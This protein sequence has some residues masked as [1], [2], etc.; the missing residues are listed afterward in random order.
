MKPTDLSTDRWNRVSDVLLQALE[1]SSGER[2]AVLDQLC[3]GDEGL[4]DE[5]LTFLEAHEN[6][7]SGFLG[8]L[9]GERTAHLLR[10]NEAVP[11]E[12]GPYRIVDELGRGGM[13]VVYRAQRSDG[14]FEQQVALKLIKRG[15]DSDA[16]E[17]RFLYER[18]ILARLRHPNIASLLD[19][20][21]SEQGQ[22]YFAMESVDGL[23]ITTYCDT[24][25]AP[26]EERLELFAE[27]GK[28]VQYAHANLVVHR[29]LKPSNM[30]VDTE[31]RVKLLDFGIAKVLGG[32]PETVPVTV[33]GTRVMTPDYAAPEQIEGHSVTTATDVYALGVVLYELLT[34]HRPH[35]F[36]SGSPA[37]L[38]KALDDS[39][40][41]APSSAVY[42]PT[43]SAAVDGTVETESPT[44][45][46]ERRSLTVE[47]LHRRLSGDLDAIV[48][49]ALRREPDRR[50]VSVEALLEDLRRHRAGLPVSARRE[51]VRYRTSKFVRRHRTGVAA[52]LLILLSVALGLGAAVW[53]AARANRERDLAQLEADKSRHVASFM[54]ELFQ[55]SDPAISRGRDVTVR[56]LLDSG[57]VRVSRELSEQPEVQAQMMNAI[58]RA[59]FGLGLYEQAKPML[60]ESLN[61][62]Q[63]TQNID[64]M[65]VA[66]GHYCLAS[67]LHEEGDYEGAERHYRSSLEIRRKLPG[68]RQPALVMG[69]NGLAYALRG[70]GEFAESETLYREALALGR[71]SLDD[72]SPEL[73]VSLN[74]LAAALGNQGKSAAAEPFYREALAL[75]LSIHGEDH[76]YVATSLYNL[77]LLLHERGD[78]EEAKGLYEKTIELESRLLGERHPTIA[79]DLRALAKLHYDMGRL[80]EAESI[81]TRALAI[82]R[83]GLPERHSR[84]A[85]TLLV[86]GRVYLAT[87]RAKEALG[88]IEEAL[89]IRQ[90]SLVPSAWQVGEAIHVLGLCY[91]GL[92]RH[93]EA[94]SQLVSGYETLLA[95]RGPGDSHTRDAKQNLFDFYHR[96]NQ[97]EKAGLYG[98]GDEGP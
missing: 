24:K 71:Q 50:Y 67:V 86:L 90:E 80:A 31:G 34:G 30:L 14:N 17:Q 47:K 78:Y 97:P 19:G 21:I 8:P 58:G 92:G 94:E 12:I 44:A 56:E 45:L 60:Q 10:A 40:V 16:I 46:S 89:S 29:D 65:A 69:I 28:A 36:T 54:A 79:I 91:A 55:T 42:R 53:Q 61:L 49:K 18:Q 15:M 73:A 32:E 66:E 22:P 68:D 9:E 74:G 64:D 95:A 6:A 7:G 93:R 13:G 63:R 81:S 87:G 1:A 98:A 51:N 96:S 2:P 43:Q 72:K 39:R 84:T 59:Y 27:V 77:A 5:V 3:E 25:K 38:H 82:Q 23:P 33:V 26:I 48:L 20:G 75:N 57:A 76:P 88:L 37:E 41:L 83:E 70:K 62:R 85:S 4:R 35:R 11:D 52:S